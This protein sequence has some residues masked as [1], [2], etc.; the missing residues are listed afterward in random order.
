VWKALFKP[1]LR[2][3][4]GHHLGSVAPSAWLSA[5]ID[6]PQLFKLRLVVAAIGEKDRRGWWNSEVLN[7]SGRFLYEQNFPRSAPFAQARAAF[8]VAQLACD[9]ALGIE[10]S[11]TGPQICHLFRLPPDVEDAFE[12]ERER[13]LDQAQAWEDT[14]EGVFALASDRW[15]QVLGELAGLDGGLIAWGESQKPQTAK[16]LRLADAR[17]LGPDELLRLAAGFAC[18]RAGTLVVPYLQLSA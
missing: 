15:P 6:F 14:V 18:G 8:R 3:A 4:C 5:L 16:A 7:D 11:A 10:R 2:A 1:Q 12:N 9:E 13:W 17:H